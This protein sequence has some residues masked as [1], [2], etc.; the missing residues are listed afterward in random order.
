MGMD[1]L[2]EPNYKVEA[3][4]ICPL[5]CEWKSHEILT[6]DQMAVQYSFQLGPV[7]DQSGYLA[8]NW[9]DYK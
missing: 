5:V 4:S 3:R 2:R 9:V 6:R 7:G 1:K 8:K